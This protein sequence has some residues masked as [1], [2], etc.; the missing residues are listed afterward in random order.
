MVRLRVGE[1]YE[2]YYTHQ[3]VIYFRRP[4]IMFAQRTKKI[5]LFSGQRQIELLDSIRAKPL[6]EEQIGKSGPNLV[7]LCWITWGR[8]SIYS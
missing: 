4:Q 6:L 5:K 7:R 8:L 2:Y 1:G 3:N